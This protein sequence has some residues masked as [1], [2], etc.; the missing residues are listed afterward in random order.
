MRREVMETIAGIEIFPL[1]SLVIFVTF[2]AGMFYWVMTVDK[3]YL[4]K[5]SNMPLDE[6]EPMPDSDSNTEQTVSES[7]SRNDING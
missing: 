3:S 6:D 1:I 5:N 4:D 2:F 7:D